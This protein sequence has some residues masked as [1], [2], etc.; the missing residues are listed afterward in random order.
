MAHRAGHQLALLFDYDGTLVPLASHPDLA[1]LNPTTRRLL[2]ELG[3]L[4]RVSVGIISGR[5]L[6]DLEGLVGL[7][8]LCYAGVSG[9]DMNLRGTR[10]HHPQAVEAVTHVRHVVEQLEAVLARFPGA[11]IEN[12]HIGLTVH[13]RQLAPERIPP[14]RARV[15]QVVEEVS[16]P[17]R[18]VDGPL[19]LEITPAGGCHKGSAVRTII[20]NL[21]P[22]QSLCLYAGDEANDVEAFEEVAARGGMTIGVG[23]QAPASAQLRI[24]TP[25]DLA[26]FLDDLC[27]RLT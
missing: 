16:A 27:H 13:V 3:R 24:N 18:I 17:L 19:A 9:L 8:D 21:G 7:T 14:F 10:I 23:P 26:A 1:I 6:D 22:L 15:R 12:K 4:P 25:R 5:A 2:E 20:Q 11:W